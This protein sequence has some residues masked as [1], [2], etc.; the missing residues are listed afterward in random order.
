MTNEKECCGTCW[1]YSQTQRKCLLTRCTEDPKALCR[2]GIYSPMPNMPKE[3]ERSQED[4][5]HS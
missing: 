5:E 1:R 4:A 2:L 3:D